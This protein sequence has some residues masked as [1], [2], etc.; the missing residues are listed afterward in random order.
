MLM[1]LVSKRFLAL[2]GL[3]L[4]VLGLSFAV[5]VGDYKPPDL[6]QVFHAKTYPIHEAHDD[7]HVAIALDPYFEA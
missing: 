4:F 6:P 2:F 5:F 3:I 7:E 1:V